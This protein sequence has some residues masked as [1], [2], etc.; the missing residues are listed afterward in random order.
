MERST[1][2]KRIAELFRRA[3]PS[4]PLSAE[5]LDAVWA[6][7][8]SRLARGTSLGAWLGASGVL[9]IA[10]G[11]FLWVRDPE[12]RPTDEPPPVVAIEIE[13]ATTPTPTPPSPIPVPPPVVAGP[14]P[15]VRTPPAPAPAP[16]VEPEEEDP[17]L[18]E[19]RLL[20]KAV[21]QLRDQ[22]EPAAS[23]QTLDEYAARFSQGVLRNEAALTRVEALVAAGRRSDALAVLES[24][25]LASSPRGGEL[26]VLRGEL[27]LDAG[28]LEDAV[29]EFE[30]ALRSGLRIE[31]EA[32]AR[33]GLDRARAQNE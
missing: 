4:E 27:L 32:R 19:S 22:H 16:P 14:L 31:I 9:L 12:V 10:A 8:S 13:A 2:D 30:T 6:K 17:V 24:A 25:D 7:T 21:T 20:T 15:R 5:A 28:R 33:Q 3:G 1:Q 29:R 23:L 18:A 11:W 26:R